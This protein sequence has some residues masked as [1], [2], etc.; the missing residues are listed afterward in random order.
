MQVK[1]TQARSGD[2]RIRIAMAHALAI[3][4]L[5]GGAGGS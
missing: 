3:D 5:N 4:A 1:R 2:D